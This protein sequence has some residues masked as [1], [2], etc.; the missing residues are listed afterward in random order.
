MKKRAKK[1]FITGLTGQDGYY[2]SKF[3]IEK[4]YKVFGLIR[5]TSNDPLVRF[6][7]EVEYLKKNITLLYGNMRDEKTL[8]SALKASKPDEI[9]NLAAQSDVGISFVCP[10]ESWDVN[11]EGTGR[12][13]VNALRINPKVKIYQASTSEMYGSTP[14]PQNEET[15]FMP[16]S[17][18]AEAKL[19]AHRDFVV[20]LRKKKP[21]FI[22]SGILFNHESPVRGEHFVTRKITIS[23]AKIKLGIQ[24]Y[25]ELGNLDAKR[26][27]GFAGDYV[28]AMW[29][30]LQQKRPDDFVVGTGE[31]R[32]VREF[33]EA[34]AE[35]LGMKITWKGKGLREVGVDEKG[36]V[37]VK[38]N[39]KYHRPNEVHFLLANP[40]KVATILKW[41]PKVSFFALVKMMVDFDYADLKK[42]Y[43]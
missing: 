36:I 28:E 5:R 34:A 19:K 24:E 41:K 23:L 31:S 25:F 27:W 6:G 21:V 12:L 42:K 14:P 33:V 10:D 18:Y 11:Y 35:N 1:A 13:F 20:A 8:I 26:D 40:H 39:K 22:A 4:G 30:M 43:S 29:L 38:V 9:Y 37:R 2:L 16:V 7:N 3:L 32:S 17:P 15:R